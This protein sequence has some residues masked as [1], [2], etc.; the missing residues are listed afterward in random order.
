MTFLD[1]AAYFEK[2]YLKPAGYVDGRKVADV[3]SISPAMAA[4]KALKDHFGKRPLRGITI[5]ISGLSEPR[6]LQPRRKPASSAPSRRSTAELEKLR[7]LLN[8]AQREGWIVRNPMHGGDPLIST[9]DEKKR[10]RIITRDEELRLLNA[11]DAPSPL[12][13]HPNLRPR[14]RHEARRDIVS[15]SGAMSISRIAC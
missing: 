8:I 13:A 12:A 11:C 14:H 15:A 7:R 2:H 5:A 9:A 4:V 10:E 3:R 1:L 6:D